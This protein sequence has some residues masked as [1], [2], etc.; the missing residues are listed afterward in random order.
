MDDASGEPWRQ[1]RRLRRRVHVDHVARES[2]ARAQPALPPCLRSSA[3]ASTRAQ[4]VERQRRLRALRDAAHRT[5]ARAR[6]TRRRDRWR[7]AGRTRT[8][9][10][11]HRARSSGDGT[12]RRRGTPPG[13]TCSL[14]PAGMAPASMT[15][16]SVPQW[17]RLAPG[18]ADHQRMASTRSAGGSARASRALPAR[19]CM[20]RSPRN[21]PFQI[22]ELAVE[23]PETRERHQVDAVGRRRGPHGQERRHDLPMQGAG[24]VGELRQVVRAR[25]VS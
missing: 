22:A 7:R 12:A 5:G 1:Q 15:S 10:C 21:L 4:P 24:R 6:V 14:Y 8:R 19:S 3:A 13:T 18:S 20:G 11:A 25:P 9:A 23:I 2:C 17:C 16:K